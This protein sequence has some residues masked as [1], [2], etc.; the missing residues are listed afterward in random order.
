MVPFQP[1]YVEGSDEKSI[2][3]NMHFFMIITRL[4][5]NKLY[6]PLLNWNESNK[7]LFMNVILLSMAMHEIN[8]FNRS[9][10]YL[11]LNR[12]IFSYHKCLSE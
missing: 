6:T 10:K 5:E 11:L 2:S 7:T 4:H 1:K 8:W 3:M 9:L 12:L